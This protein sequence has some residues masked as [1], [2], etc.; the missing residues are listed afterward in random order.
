MSNFETIDSAL[1]VTATGGQQAGGAGPEQYPDEGAP[2]SRTWGQM[3]RQYAASC[4]QGAGQSLMYGGRPRN[5]RE[6]LTT[7]AMGCAIGMGQRA[8]DDI[9]G[10]IGGG[11]Q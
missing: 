9:S 11:E 2:Q 3:A 10:A 4:V 7:A 8:V 6:G 1:L 5:V